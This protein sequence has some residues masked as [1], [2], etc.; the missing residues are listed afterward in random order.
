GG[1]CPAG[2][3]VPDWWDIH[4]GSIIPGSPHWSADRE[5]PLEPFGFVW[6]CHWGD[7]SSWKFQFLDL[8]GIEAGLIARD[9]R[10]GYVELARATWSNPCINPPS[11]VLDRPSS[12]PPFISIHRSP[13]KA[14]VTFAV[15]MAFDLETGVCPEW[16]R[17]DGPE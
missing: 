10:F 15:A 11:D 7:D 9:E 3:Y 2:F 13:G 4:D 12:P 14:L 6:G 5:W 16:Q 1:F 17:I 8:S